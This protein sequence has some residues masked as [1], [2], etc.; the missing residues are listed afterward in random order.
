MSILLDKP[1]KHPIELNRL[2]FWITFFALLFL[3]RWLN[4]FW[5]FEYP[6]LFSL[7]RF[8]ANKPAEPAEFSR[9]VTVTSD[10]YEGYFGGTSPLDKAK[11]RC[12]ID[13][14]FELGPAVVVLDFDTSSPK[15]KGMSP[16][17]P[18]A[19]V[20]ARGIDAGLPG[21]IVP[22]PVLG[23]EDSPSVHSGLALFPR[24][25]DWT[26]R[27][28]RKYL[29]TGDGH[30]E[31][32]LHW[33]AIDA[34]CRV[35]EARGEKAGPCPLVANRSGETH[36]A[37]DLLTSLALARRYSFPPLYLDAFVKPSSTGVC[38]TTWGKR[39]PSLDNPLHDKIVFL[40]GAYSP[41]DRHPTPFGVKTGV[42]LMAMATESDFHPS[43]VESASWPITWALEI[44][45]FVVEVVLGLAVV[46]FYH[47]LY[48]RVALV[49]MFIV[50]CIAFVASYLLF[51][52]LDYRASFV[53][54]VIGM[55]I[56][57]LYEST[58]RAEK[59]ARG[60]SRH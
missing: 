4:H 1:H 58:E 17:H 28:Y 46:W 33:A 11:L 40:G 8:A 12:A 16:P 15:F 50:T 9:V 52:Y 57:Q 60:I 20:W 6:A 19:L 5:I 22:A 30:W 39:T 45:L 27:D 3:A 10:D 24:S 35:M 2:S 36:A 37:E 34:Y 41:D 48:P 47:K 25:P 54:F 53:P 18:E 7:D 21:T 42:E 26:V 32:T 43:W 44:I 29:Q 23:G 49:A 56:A 14:L 38:E 55:W 31:P 13:K 51:W 59:Q